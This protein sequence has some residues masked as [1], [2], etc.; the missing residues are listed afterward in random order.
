MEARERE[1][2]VAGQRDNEIF[3]PS[4]GEG[5]TRHETRTEKAVLT[6]STRPVENFIC[7]GH[8]KGPEKQK[9]KGFQSQRGGQLKKATKAK[10]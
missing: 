4:Y 6:E 10:R 1:H 2:M 5:P 9:I 3:I 7:R 8:Q